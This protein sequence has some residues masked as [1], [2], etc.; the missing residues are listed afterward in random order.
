MNILVKG[1]GYL[2]STT[3]MYTSISRRGVHDL[4]KSPKYHAGVIITKPTQPRTQAIPLLKS[5]A[6]PNQRTYSRSVDG[7]LYKRG[8]HMNHIAL[9]TVEKVIP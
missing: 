7:W 3:H 5:M 6:L 9:L 4:R 8:P 2:Y 1:V